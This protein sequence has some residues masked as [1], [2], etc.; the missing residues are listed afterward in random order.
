MSPINSSR[1]QT[2]KT[3]STL[4]SSLFLFCRAFF[5]LLCVLPTCVY[6]H[7]KKSI[8]SNQETIQFPS[9]LSP[10]LHT[11]FSISLSCFFF[12]GAFSN[13]R[14]WH[15]YCFFLIHLAMKMTL[16]STFFA[17]SL[18]GDVNRE[19]KEWLLFKWC[20]FKLTINYSANLTRRLTLLLLYR[21]DVSA[22]SKYIV[23]VCTYTAEVS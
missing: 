12:F 4:F 8:F 14:R 3:I 21:V 9:Y 16:Y 10:Q 19:K 22:F 23:C 5:L 18:D 11:F 17:D 20:R 7:I 15:I 6:A 1:S 13:H 2:S